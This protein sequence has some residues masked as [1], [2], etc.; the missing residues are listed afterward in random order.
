[1]GFPLQNN[2]LMHVIIIIVSLCF[3]E[4]ETLS[5]LFLKNSYGKV[6]SAQ[7]LVESDVGLSV[8]IISRKLMLKDKF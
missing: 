1:M 6:T 2:Q 7:V 3:S 8:H 5:R 4:I